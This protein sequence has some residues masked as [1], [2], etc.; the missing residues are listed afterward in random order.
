MN[1]FDSLISELDDLQIRISD[2]QKTMEG[3]NDT[4]SS[5]KSDHIDL[6]NSHQLDEDFEQ[7][8]LDIQNNLSMSISQ[9]E[10]MINGLFDDERL[11][12][13][14]DFFKIQQSLVE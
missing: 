6:S 12:H 7:T 3:L 1:N 8:L 2:L 10:E 14:N 9:T 11:E 13:L 5:L 4:H